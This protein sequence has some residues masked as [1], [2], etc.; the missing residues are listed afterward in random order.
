MNNRNRLKTKLFSYKMTHDSGFAPNPFH[1]YMTLACCKPGI[2]RTK[3]VNDWVA[4]FTSRYL[5]GD[6]PGEERLIFLMKITEIVTYEQYWKQ[7]RFKNKK[8]VL[9]SENQ[10]MKRGD[11]IYQPLVIN[12]KDPKDFKQIENNNHGKDQKDHDLNGINVLI[13]KQFYYFGRYPQTIPVRYKPN[14]PKYSTC[15]GILT[16]IDP[17]DIDNSIIGYIKHSFNRGRLNLPTYWIIQN[18]SRCH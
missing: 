1:G 7:V 9:N 8:P 16:E 13:S 2:R 3:Q 5:N 11:N 17:K 12:P 18:K 15:N 4:G 6:E 10:K 14:V